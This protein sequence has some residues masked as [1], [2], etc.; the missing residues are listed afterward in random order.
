MHALARRYVESSIKAHGPFLGEVVEFGSRN[1]NGDVRDLFPQAKSYLGIDEMPGKG[2][3]LVLDASKWHPIKK[4]C[5]VIST[6]TFEHTSEWKKMLKIAS[7]AL[8]PKGVLIVTCATNPRRAHSATIV[9][10]SP[11][12]DEYYANVA[13]DDFVKAAKKLGFKTNIKVDKVNGDLYATCIY[14]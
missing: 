2:V 9:N 13:E 4:Y 5:C 12:K 8:L 14:G 6:E 7:E 11:R 3:D 10:S 1:I